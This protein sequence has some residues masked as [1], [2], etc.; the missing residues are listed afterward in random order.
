MKPSC[1]IALLLG[2]VSLRA[3]TPPRPVGLREVGIETAG[4]LGGGV[5]GGAAGCAAGAAAGFL[6]FLKLN[7]SGNEWASIPIIVGGMGG[8]AAGIPL[9]CGL[10]AAKAGDLAGCRGRPWAA[11]LG[12]YL[13]AGAGAG[14]ALLVR[15]NTGSLWGWALAPTGAVGGAV[16]GYSLSVDGRSSGNV[17]RWLG[18]ALAAALVRTEAGA[19]VAGSVRIIGYGI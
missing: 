7:Q 5:L 14:A 18:P 2:A 4:A 16:A 3:A 11:V 9:G 6:L 12:S 8:A 17:G 13:G 19:D 1:L 15:H 10:G